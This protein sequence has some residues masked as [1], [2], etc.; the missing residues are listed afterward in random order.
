MKEK[1]DLKK[2]WIGIHLGLTHSCIAVCRGGMKEVES[3]PDHLGNTQIPSCVEFTDKDRFI[4]DHQSKSKENKIFDVKRIIG[5]KYLSPMVQRGIKF[6]SFRLDVN[7]QDKPIIVVKYKN[8][9]TQF[10]PEEIYSIIITHLKDMG[11]EYLGGC[12]KNAVITVP[13]YFTD[14]QRMATKDG[15]T[16]AGLDVIRIINEPT[17]AA[18]ANGFAEVIHEENLIVFYLGGCTCDVSILSIEDGI[19]E[20]KGIEGSRYLGGMDF[21][22]RIIEYCKLV[23]REKNMID[24]DIDIDIPDSIMDLLKYESEQVKHILSTKTEA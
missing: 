14:A 20:I 15:G 21:D 12:I 7:T 19:F 4:S 9:L 1:Q 8:K 22:R 5:Q 3:I 16:I 18:I 23:M 17:S 10:A 6:W 11:E 24:I 13:A 2:Y